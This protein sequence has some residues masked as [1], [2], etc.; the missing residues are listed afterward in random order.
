MLLA[1][2]LLVLGGCTAGHQTSPTGDNRPP[3][4]ESARDFVP[5]QPQEWKLSNGLTM[6]FIRDTELPTVNGTLYLRGGSLWEELPASVSVMAS[7]LRDGGTLALKPEALDERLEELGASIS[8]TA[9]QENSAVSFFSLASDL[10]EVMSLVSD[11]VQRPAFDESRFTLWQARQLDG[12]KRRTE[13]PSTVVDLALR[14]LTFGR[15]G[16]YGRVII[17][18]DVKKLSVPAM[19]RAFEKFVRPDDAILA[20]SGDVDTEHL[21]ALVERNFGG[22]AARGTPLPPPPAIPAP[23]PAGIY[24]IKMPFEQASVSAGQQGISLHTPDEFDIRLLNHLYGD[25]SFGSL[26]MQRVR[27]DEGLAYGVA[28]L[29]IP[30]Y[31][32]GM[33]IISVQTRAEAAAKALG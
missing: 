26:L 29:I 8:S 32:R 1:G 2:F 5:Q 15:T 33:N 24:F 14:E 16:P 21:R 11:V 6:L 31:V 12:I 19:R 30:A 25:G 17:S 23:M 10:D 7:Q 27:A 4:V 22:W 13:D 28:G 9:S 20:V 3:L 18:E